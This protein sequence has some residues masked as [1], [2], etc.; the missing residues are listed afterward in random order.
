MRTIAEIQTKITSRLHGSTLNKVSDF[1]GLCEDAAELVLSRI[2][3][4]ETNR[5]VS[6]IN[7]VY[8]NV[9]DYA[10]PAD[11]KVITDLTPQAN[12]DNIDNSSLSRTFSREFVNNKK[13]NQFAVVWHDGVRFLRYSKFLKAPV[14]IDQADS[15]TSN[16][17]WTIGGNASNLELDTYNFVSGSGSLKCNVSSPGALL[18]V[19]IRIGNDSSNYF[20]K[21]VTA[22]HFEAFKA[23]W[24]LLRFDLNTATQVGTVNMAAVDYVRV[25]TT[26]NVNQTAFYEKTLT[27]R[28]DLSKNYKSDGAIFLYQFFDSISTLSLVRL[29][30]IVAAIGSLFDVSYNSIYLFRSSAGVW[31][32]K[33]TSATDII[34]LSGLSYNIFEAEISRAI[35]Q[36]VQGPMGVFD[37]TYWNNMLEGADG[38]GE[39]TGLYAEYATKNPSERIDGT[40]TYYRMSGNSFDND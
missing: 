33:P 32:S 36:I 2:D 21:T 11:L 25:T 19:E 3:P 26:Y 9:Y 16:G 29:D 13:D 18:N 7:P 31:K 1:Y 34:N 6:L 39:N 27:Q 17:T 23:G 14:V 28:L 35:T 20:A 22:G 12:A 30:N 40:T 5:K 24:N 37:Y 15:L 8:D 4:I 38:T 10:L